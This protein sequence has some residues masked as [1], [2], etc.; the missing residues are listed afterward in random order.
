MKITALCGESNW[1][2]AAQL[3]PIL[4]KAVVEYEKAPVFMNYYKNL[5]SEHGYKV[6]DPV[7]KKNEYSNKD[8]FNDL[9]E[10]AIG[11]GV[12]RM[13]NGSGKKLSDDE[14]LKEI[15]S[16]SYKRAKRKARIKAKLGF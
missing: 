13:F 14:M 4:Y 9:L 7:N 8:L 12:D 3:Y 11:A 16:K 6:K 5:I 10:G 15:D 1:K 2:E